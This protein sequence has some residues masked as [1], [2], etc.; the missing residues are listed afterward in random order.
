[1]TLKEQIIYQV[2]NRVIDVQ[3]FDIHQEL[4]EFMNAFG[5]KPEDTGGQISF[6]GKDP[7]VP[8]TIRFATATGI[9]LA[10]KAVAIAKLWK[11]RTGESQDIAIDLRKVIHRLSP[12]FQGKWEK[13]NGFSPGFP[14]ELGSPFAPNFYATKDGRHVVPLDF[15]NRLRIAT[16]KFLNVPEDK[17]AIAA[18]IA[19]WNAEELEQEANA[20]G[21]V[22]TKLRTVEEFLE[23]EQFQVLQGQPIIRIEKIADTA[24]IP[25][26]ED[27]RS[28]LDGIRALGMG[29]VIAG[30]GTGRA[31][32]LHGADVLNIWSLEDTEMESL[33]ATADVG[34]RSAKLNIKSPEGLEKMRTLIA[35]ADVFFANR[36]VG[37]LE[38]Y[39]LSA[40]DMAAIKPGIIH[41]TVSLY[42]EEGPW[43]T[44]GGFDVSAGVATGIMALE[45]SLAEP[46]LPSI[47]V[48]DDYLVAWLMSAGIAEALV[49]RAKEGGS[50]KIHICL[51]RTILWMFQLGIFDMD[52][53]RKTAGS[54]EEH[55]LLDPVLFSAE[56]PLGTYQGVA[57]QVDMSRTPGS[58]KYALLPRG[59]AQPEWE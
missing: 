23:T 37:Y 51:S 38:K 12:F 41:A 24:P 44:Y 18:A 30:A 49:R 20:A 48:V 34:M 5:L 40:E 10:T 54:G 53:A 21:L 47:M 26:K 25:L 55:L 50:Y 42:G 56:T 9:G 17:E 36:R 31:L 14:T 11:Y 15:Y 8:S 33:Y 4:A 35:G 46:K 39:G 22:M 58:Y 43:A 28:P 19:R 27:P 6:T 13:L 57:E 32:A 3:D 52:Y 59:A 16:L 2:N 45:G 7:I 29:H 1:M